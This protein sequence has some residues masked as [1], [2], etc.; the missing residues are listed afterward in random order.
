LGDF[1]LD[2]VVE[3]VFLVWCLGGSGLDEGGKRMLLV[4]FL[5]GLDDGV[6]VVC[7]RNGNGSDVAVVL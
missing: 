6:E 1:V 7:I 4:V 3:V 5:V 2:V